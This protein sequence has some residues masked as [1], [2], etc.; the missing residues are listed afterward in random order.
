MTTDNVLLELQDPLS[1]VL[2]KEAG[3]DRYQC[4]IMPMRI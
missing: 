4:V 3:N 2:M 1:P